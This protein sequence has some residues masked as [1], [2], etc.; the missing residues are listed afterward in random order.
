SARDCSRW[1]YG[2]NPDLNF[3]FTGNCPTG[4]TLWGRLLLRLFLSGLGLFLLLQFGRIGADLDSDRIQ[5]FALGLFLG[6]LL[7]FTI[8]QPLIDIRVR[9]F[10]VQ[11]EGLLDVFKP[12]VRASHG[13]LLIWQSGRI[14]H[15]AIVEIVLADEGFVLITSGLFVRALPVLN[16]HRII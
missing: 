8:K 1:L 12:L 15:V 2:L 11:F 9:V 4:L 3:T 13:P 6:Q 16:G 14:I 10:G 7:T 5:V